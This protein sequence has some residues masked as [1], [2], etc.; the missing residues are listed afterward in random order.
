[1]SHGSDTALFAALFDAHAQEL[2]R[3][4]WRRSG[5]RGRAEDLVSVV[6]L[7]AWRRRGALRHDVAARPWLYGIAVNVLRND[8]RALR[9]HRAAIE[10]IAASTP[11]AA[12]DTEELAAINERL[13]AALEGL[14]A[15]PRREQEVI[16]LCVW[17][18][19]SYDE[20]AI[21]L[22]VPVGT[23]RSRLS[24]ARLRLRGSNT[25]A[26]APE[27]LHEPA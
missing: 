13:H 27:H 19:L 8:R 18:Q 1:M 12:P 5:D 4:C 11:R 6:F 23:V 9:R 14:L 3:F 10:R 25:N 15:L 2:M 22:G 24:R 17:S 16:A 26:N 21:A 20:A 7:E